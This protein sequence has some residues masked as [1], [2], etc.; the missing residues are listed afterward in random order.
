[1]D[2]GDCLD[3]EPPQEQAEPWHLSERWLH[4]SL[5]YNEW[6]ASTVYKKSFF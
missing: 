5:L 2:N 3:P 4:D 6:M 1:M